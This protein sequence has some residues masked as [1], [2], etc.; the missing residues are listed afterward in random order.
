MKELLVYNKQFVADKKYLPY[1]TSKHPDRKL[2]VLTCMD[3]RLTNLLPDALGLKNGDAVFIKN[4]GAWVMH[5]FGSIIRS[6]LVAI[7]DQ[8]VDTIWV[9][10][11]TDCGAQKL[12]VD[13]MIAKMEERGIAAE[14]LQLLSTYEPDFNTMLHSIVDVGQ[15]VEETVA[16]LQNHP[17]FPKDV[18]IKG[19]VVDTVTGE[20]SPAA[21]IE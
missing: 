12:S 7:Y 4:A 15:S 17:L 13:G 9:V 14:T 16:F 2:A 19:F 21:S 8:G 11:H 10:G 1:Q 5:P 6:L 20:L 18:T 3:T